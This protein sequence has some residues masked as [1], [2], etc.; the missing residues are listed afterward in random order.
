MQPFI[1]PQPLG[2][3]SPLRHP[4]SEEL[5]WDLVRDYP[6]KP[7]NCIRGGLV[8]LVAEAMGATLEQ[9]LPTATAMELSQNWILIHD[10]FEDGSEMRRGKPC[11]HRTAGPDQAINAGD[12]LHLIQWGV[13]F[14][15]YEVL[16]PKQTIEIGRDFRDMLLRTAQGQTAELAL[17]DSYDLTETDVLYISVHQCTIHV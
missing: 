14:D 9:A 12:T 11:L 6:D 1:Q 13:L 17:R 2:S 16:K 7:G 5:F 10:E 3:V 8:C 4:S 15:N